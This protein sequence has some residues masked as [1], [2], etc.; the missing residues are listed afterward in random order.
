MRG[1]TERNRLIYEVCETLIAI[2]KR[3]GCRKGVF[4][5]VARQHQLSRQRVWAIYQKEKGNDLET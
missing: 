3:E 1:K 2:N 5:H 4:S